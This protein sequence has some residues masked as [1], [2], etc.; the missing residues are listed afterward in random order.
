[1]KKNGIDANKIY[2][3]KIVKS[4]TLNYDNKK[5][6]IL[7]LVKVFYSLIYFNLSLISLYFIQNQFIVN[8]SY[9]FQCNNQLHLVFEYLSGGLFMQLELGQ[10]FEEDVAR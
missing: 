10:C 5:K 6:N 1:M 3:L 7:S 4:A 2:D 9:A 8:I